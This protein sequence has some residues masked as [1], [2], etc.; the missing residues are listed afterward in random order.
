MT[1]QPLIPR[2]SRAPHALSRSSHRLTGAALAYG[3]AGVG[4]A[5]TWIAVVLAVWTVLR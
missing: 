1:V 4:S 2:L 5:A 3:I